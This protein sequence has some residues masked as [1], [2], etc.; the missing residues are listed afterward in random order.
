LKILKLF[1]FKKIK[2]ATNMGYCLVEYY[3]DVLFLYE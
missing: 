1:F 2:I 3:N